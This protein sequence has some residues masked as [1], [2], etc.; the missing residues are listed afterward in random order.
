MSSVWR[1]GR[2]RAPACP[3]CGADHKSGWRENGDAYDGVDL[4]N[5]DFNYD[6]FVKEEFGSQFKP[7]G[8]RTVWW[9]AGF[10]LIL[11]FLVM[12]L[13]R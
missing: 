11:A 10:L 9:I 12:Y 6:E 2:A 7:P 5:E 13:L 3:G 8:T 1:T 4:P